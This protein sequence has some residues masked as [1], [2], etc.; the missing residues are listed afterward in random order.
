MRKKVVS[1]IIIFIILFSN[2]AFAAT[3]APSSSD[4]DLKDVAQIIDDNTY[5][6]TKYTAESN[7]IEIQTGQEIYTNFGS[8]KILTGW[9]IGQ[10]QTFLQTHSQDKLYQDSSDGSYKVVF[11]QEGDTNIYKQ[12]I[13]TKIDDVTNI[14]NKYIIYK[15]AIKYGDS[16]YD[17]KIEI[18][19]FNRSTN[20]IQFRFLV[21]V[22]EK[23]KGNIGENNLTIQAYK[24]LRPEIGALGFKSEEG[25]NAEISVNYTIGKYDENAKSFTADDTISGAF[26]LGEVD[27]AQGIAVKDFTVSEEEG[28]QNVL[29]PQSLYEQNC[30][31]YQQ[32]NNT[33]YFYTTNENNMSSDK[34]NIFLLMDKVY[35]I[36]MTLTFSK[37]NAGSH[38]VFSSDEFKKEN[39]QQLEVIFDT[40]GGF[41]YQA[42]KF[43]SKGSTVTEP[44]ISIRK[45]GYKFTGWYTDEGCTTKYDFTTPVENNITLYAGWEAIE[46]TITYHLDG[47]TNN[48][49][50][51]STYKITD[52]VIFSDPKKDGYEFGG[53][54]EDSSFSGN[55]ITSIPKGSTGNRE[56]YA[57][58][59]KKE[60]SAT[61]ATYTVEY[62]F[63]NS[64]GTYDSKPKYTEE[65]TG[66]IG[67]TVTATSKSYPGYKEN[68]TYKDRVASGQVTEDESLTL[69][70]Y[71]DRE[72][73]KVTFDPQG[74]TEAKE[75]DLDIQI[76]KYTDKATKPADPKKDGYKFLYWY[77]EKDGKEIQYDFDDE[78]LSDVNLIA[79]W[80]K[81]QANNDNP[82]ST[83]T[84]TAGKTD[85]TTATKI[86]PN[87]GIAGIAI[88]IISI[89]VMAFFGIRY[90]VLRNK[91]K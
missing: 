67:T 41:P 4:K 56:L 47:G 87:T 33:T 8:G 63:E 22:V 77:Y 55:Q 32:T 49:S 44:N 18:A 89:S 75:G 28:K 76:V 15:N 30:I 71:Y 17:V 79:K 61:E 70:L 43:V 66:T 6:G 42:R 73:Y 90:F 58:W 85:P 68:T 62:Y 81:V 60:P 65:K 5:I 74:G 72:E 27:R 38:F 88:I 53:W 83:D 11:Q 86:L 36:P 37:Y 1:L 23:T 51:P 39:E 16:Y 84:P 10:I 64:D 34:S 69:K 78:V 26:T 13:Q 31:K 14:K 80:T 35:T 25:E 45:D 59:T 9:D 7:C 12:W 48:S 40:R 24:G 46:Y 21:G 82:E 19:S 57:K 2:C 54:Y 20:N 52:Y 91:M 29:I 3:Y 50:N